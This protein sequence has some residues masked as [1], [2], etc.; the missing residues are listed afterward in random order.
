MK[1][2][3]MVFMVAVLVSTSS[4]TGCIW[5]DDWDEWLYERVIFDNHTGC[6]VDC[7]IDGYYEVTVRPHDESRIKE[8]HLEGRREF[9]ARST[10]GLIEWGP[11]YFFLDEGETVVIDLYDGGWTRSSAPA[12]VGPAAP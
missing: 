9:Y 2:R 3:L 7:Y 11:D 10:D 1:L 12:E 8:R 4:L 5:V 6:Y